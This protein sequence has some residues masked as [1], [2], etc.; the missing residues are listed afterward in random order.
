MPRGAE[1]VDR[2]F[3]IA[4]D[5]AMSVGLDGMHGGAGVPSVVA[6]LR[7]A[8]Q[9]QPSPSFAT[10]A[11]LAAPTG[12]DVEKIVKAVLAQIQI[13]GMQPSLNT[14]LIS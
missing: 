4:I 10:G 6:A 5:S 2:M 1:R 11:G 7:S 9:P 8:T 3:Q 14:A 13:A 12:Q